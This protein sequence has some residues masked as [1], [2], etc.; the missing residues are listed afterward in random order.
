MLRVLLMT[1][2]GFGVLGAEKL[3]RIEFPNSGAAAAQADFLRGV[4]LLHSFEY[5]TAAEAFTAAQKADPAFAMAYWGEAMT[6]NHG[7]WAEQDVEKGRS[8]LARAA[9]CGTER[10]CG[11]MRAVQVLYGEGTKRERDVA[12]MREM[13]KLAAKYPEDL[14]AASFH[15]LSV[16]GSVE[17]RDFRVYVQ[18]GA[19]A[20]AV[21]KKNPEHPGAVHYVIHSF[22]DP[23]HAP[24]GLE[25]ARAYARLA[26]AATHALHMPSHIFLALGMWDDVIASNEESLAAS[27]GRGYHSLQW[28]AYG[29][30]QKGN[31]ARA[32]E[33]LAHIR[34]AAE[35]EPSAG[36]RWYLSLVRAAHAFETGD[37][38]GTDFAVDTKGLEYS[39]VAADLMTRAAL[40]VKNGKLGEAEKILAAMRAG[41]EKTAL[42]A[43]GAACHQ[44]DFSTGISANGLKEAAVME[45]EVEAMLLAARGKKSAAIAVLERAA[46]LEDG[47]AMD[48]GPPVPVKPA[49]EMLGEMLLAAGRH[50]EAKAHF[51]KALQ[52][53]PGRAKALAGLRAASEKLP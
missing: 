44:T 36:A 41:R 42:R 43:G 47:M 27:K 30:L 49:H 6:Y 34:A 16:L 21:W 51:E 31:V 10:E 15:A 23:V 20:G 5:K 35:R 32:G 50:G 25:A 14:E 17:E 3:G 1:V 9:Q 38:A 48:F 37:F 40:A 29:Y 52:A 13:E 8:V 33:L 26:P 22:D 12:Y 24:L 45:M 53:A 2:L 28:L 46:V 18:A 4:L 19:L 39:A 7:L 11:Y